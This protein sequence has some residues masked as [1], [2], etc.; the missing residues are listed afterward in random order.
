MNHA[1]FREAYV[2]INDI[3]QYF[4]HYPSPQEEV[5]L[6]LHGGP[7]SS[8]AH[9]AYC[10]KPHWD[11]CNLVYYDQRGAGKTQA[12]NK[13]K[14][15]D[16]TLEKL[17][18]DLKETIAYVK[19]KYQTER[20]ILIGHSW[21]TVL[22]SQYVLCYPEDVLCFIGY[23]P[24]VDMQKG[25]RLGYDRLRE[26]IEQAGVKKDMAAI[27]ALKD[28]PF[29]VTIDNFSKA[30]L[31]VRKLQRKYGYVGGFREYLGLMRKSPVFSLRDI[32][33]LLS[34]IKTNRNLV[35]A[36]LTYTVW[37]IRDYHLPVYY[38]LGREDWQTPSVLAAEYFEQIT[39]PKKGLY[40][41]EGAKHMPDVENTA[42]FCAAMREI[43][44]GV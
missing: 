37:D 11:F 34:G 35:E 15:E 41:I 9:L 21:G 16:I 40:W 43:I 33:P 28:Y 36:L 7:G 38:V 19:E 4:L 1:Q 3:S 10:L 26:S 29:D 20:L 25:E 12:K 31:R 18:A 5:A 42:D 13:S 2:P 22:G 6:M 44:A 24:V 39:A 17:I 30:V 8:A 27:E 14:P 32:F 23:G